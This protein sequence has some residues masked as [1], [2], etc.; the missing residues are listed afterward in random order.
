VRPLQYL[1][2]MNTTFQQIIAA[3]LLGGFLSLAIA[4]LVT[5]RLPRQWLSRMVSF[6]AGLLLSIA[7]LDLLPEALEEG[8]TSDGLFQ[9]FLV[10]VLAFFA[11]E[12]ILLSTHFHGKPGEVEALSRPI[13]TILFGSALHI[14]TDGLT[15]AAAFLTSPVLGWGMTFAII[16]HEIPREGGDFSLLF[17]AGWSRKKTLLWNGISRL[18]CIVGGVMGYYMLEGARAWIAPVLTLAAASFTYIALA[19]LMPWIRAERD[20]FA[21]HGGFMAAGVAI[22]P[23]GARMLA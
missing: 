18:A 7:L 10:G 4:V 9:L 20:G 17:A 1:T 11:F 16:A 15:L 3:T 6:S 13:P 14:W 23:F 5:F 8:M 21:W 12:K 22:V 19:G 2:P